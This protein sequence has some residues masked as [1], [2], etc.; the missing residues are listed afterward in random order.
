MDDKLNF[1]KPR[2][3]KKKPKTTPIP[4]DEDT[5]MGDL[6]QHA[7]KLTDNLGSGRDVGEQEA[8]PSQEIKNLESVPRKEDGQQRSVSTSPV[9]GS[10]IDPGE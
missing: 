8:I 7:K 3:K 9:L 4:L 6:G 5:F 1:P 2:S 10:D